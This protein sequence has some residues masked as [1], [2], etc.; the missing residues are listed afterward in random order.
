MGRKVSVMN[1]LWYELDLR[2]TDQGR[3][4]L[5]S[6]PIPFVYPKKINLNQVFSTSDILNSLRIIVQ[7]G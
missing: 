6:L 7:I 5:Y 3:A 2:R 1:D 4:V